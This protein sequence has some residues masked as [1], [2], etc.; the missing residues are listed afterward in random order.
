[1]YVFVTVDA[2]GQFSRRGK[3]LLTFLSHF[4]VHRFLLIQYHFSI[5]HFNA[6]GL[7]FLHLRSNCVLWKLI[8]LYDSLNRQRIEYM[9]TI[10]IVI[11]MFIFWNQCQHELFITTTEKSHSSMNRSPICSTEYWKY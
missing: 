3:S 1:M 5:F 2:H 11:I 8:S 9:H 7:H 6:I 4:P 10:I